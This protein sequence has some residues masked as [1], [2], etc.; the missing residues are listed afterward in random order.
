MSLNEVETHFSS[1]F[2]YLIFDSFI[3]V[4]FIASF[5]MIFTSGRE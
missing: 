2:V 3:F 4:K 5:D 1:L